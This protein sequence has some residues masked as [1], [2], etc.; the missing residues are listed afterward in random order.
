LRFYC[1]ALAQQVTYRKDIRPL[2]EAKCAACHGANSPYLGD[3]EENKKK[4]YA[5]SKGPRMDTRGPAF[6]ACPIR[7]RPRAG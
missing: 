4:T 7:G 1:L 5:M 3:F 6:V 2:W